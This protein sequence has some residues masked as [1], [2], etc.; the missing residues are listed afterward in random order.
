VRARTECREVDNNMYISDSDA[1]AGIEVPEWEP[2]ALPLVV[3]LDRPPPLPRHD[4]AHDTDPGA[5]V[6]VIDLA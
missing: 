6:I 5:R 4:D 2:E 3:E 1:E